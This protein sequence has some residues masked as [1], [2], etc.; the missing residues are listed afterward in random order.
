MAINSAA[1]EWKD[2]GKESMLL[3]QTQEFHY[4]CH[5][6]CHNAYNKPFGRKKQGEENGYYVVRQIFLLSIHNPHPIATIKGQEVHS[7]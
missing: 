3:T 6:S 2:G 5:S 1:A 4:P 7:P